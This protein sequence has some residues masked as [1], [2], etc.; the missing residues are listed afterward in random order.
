M[1]ERNASVRCREVTR[2]SGEDSGEEVL[3]CYHETRCMASSRDI[4]ESDMAVSGCEASSG[5]KSRRLR[6]EI[7]VFYKTPRVTRGGESV[8]TRITLPFRGNS[9]NR[10]LR[11]FSRHLD[12]AVV[13]GVSYEARPCAGER[14]NF[15]AQRCEEVGE[16]MLRHV[17]L[18]GIRAIVYL[19][20]D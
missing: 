12:R 16:L 7:P 6:P 8:S 10:R 14:L 20:L 9:R 13:F 1:R 2:G 5:S 19:G 4:V 17:T 11:C 3:C 15:P 18:C